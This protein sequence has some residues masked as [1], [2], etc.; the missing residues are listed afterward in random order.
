LFNLAVAFERHTDEYGNRV[1]RAVA[2]SSFHHFAR[3]QLGHRK[4]VSELRHRGA[5]LCDSIIK[6]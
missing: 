2:E 4:G 6:T 1:G 3:L 5:R